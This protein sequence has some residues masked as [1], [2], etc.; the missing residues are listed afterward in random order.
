MSACHREPGGLQESPVPDY[1]LPHPVIVVLE[2]G[3][4]V[5]LSRGRPIRI[6]AK[7]T[8]GLAPSQARKLATALP[9]WPLALAIPYTHFFHHHEGSPVRGESVR[10]R[11]PTSL[12]QALLRKH[13]ALPR[14]RLMMYSIASTHPWGSPAT[15]A[16]MLGYV[17][18]ARQYAY[19]LWLFT[20]SD[21]KTI[22]CPS[23]IFALTNA[24]AAHQ[25]RLP[26]LGSAT[27]AEVS[28]K[29]PCIL[30][31][32]WLHLLPLDINNQRGA[33]SVEEDRRN[34]PWRPL[35]K[36]RISSRAARFSM[37]LSYAAAQG[38]SL[39]AGA[40]VPQGLALL[41]LGIVY[42]NLGGANASCLL[43][44]A[45]NA[46]G[47]LCFLS[48]ALEVALGHPV[49]LGL[50]STALSSPRLLVWLAIIG[51]IILTTIHAQDMYDQ[52]GDAA[53][54]R[55]T[56]PL[57]IGDTAAR[58]MIAC[59]TII[60]G[61]LCPVFWDT[62]AAATSLSVSLAAIVAARSLVFRTVQSDR[63]T[64][65]VWNIWVGFVFSLPLAAR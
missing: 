51:G 65:V 48:G 49:L 15:I 47:Y 10:G 3:S 24:A 36:G 4:G 20:Y 27:W 45:L 32:V 22:I 26:M 33:A 5:Y 1:A 28:T 44:N 46:L 60:W 29:L 16:A 21:V 13:A 34:K 52:I 11:E 64:F 59:C 43:R 8:Q 50:D 56:V 18:A 14:G 57:V 38:F 42:N 61:A 53:R 62:K 19:T 63:T 58:W 31:W 23:T 6:E 30:L 40:G 39:W 37:L 35:P 55:R 9:P 25:F 17:S 54:H 12:S 7:A 41:F 2:K